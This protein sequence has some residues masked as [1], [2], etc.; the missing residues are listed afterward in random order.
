MSRNPVDTAL[1]AAA[2]HGVPYVHRDGP[3]VVLV[4]W[5]AGSHVTGELRGRVR[6][7]MCSSS[8]MARAVA[9]RVLADLQTFPE[10][11]DVLAVSAL[12]AEAAYRFACLRARRAA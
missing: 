9:A 2:H 12:Y 4:L 5:G 10:H 6:T 11:P 7:R 8:A 1:R 3:L